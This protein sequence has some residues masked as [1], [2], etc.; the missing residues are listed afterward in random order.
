MNPLQKL[1]M[2]ILMSICIFTIITLPHFIAFQ[3]MN[4]DT[5]QHQGYEYPFW[6][7]IVCG[8]ISGPLSVIVTNKIFK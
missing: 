7:I 4:F 6:L 8:L 1:S 5:G 2:S 3:T